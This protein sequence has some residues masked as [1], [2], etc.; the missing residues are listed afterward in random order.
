MTRTLS[1][2]CCARTV[3]S[4]PSYSIHLLDRFSFF[5]VVCMISLS[6]QFPFWIFI[7]FSFYFLFLFRLSKYSISF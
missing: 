3:P 6:L 4:V 7:Q 5:S 2:C 1:G